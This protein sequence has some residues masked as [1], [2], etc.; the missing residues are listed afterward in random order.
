MASGEEEKT[1]RRRKREKGAFKCP[2]GVEPPIVGF[3]RGGV[4]SEATPREGLL[5]GTLRAE[6][7]MAQTGDSKHPNHFG[8]I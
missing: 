4:W 5:L 3:L 2:L 1:M 7:G 6:F 8:Y